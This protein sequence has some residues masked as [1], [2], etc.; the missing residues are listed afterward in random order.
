[1]CGCSENV[2]AGGG[3]APKQIEKMSYKELLAYL[4]RQQSKKT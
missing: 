2:M 1:M 4:K 3:G